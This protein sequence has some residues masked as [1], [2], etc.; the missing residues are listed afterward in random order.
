MLV[1]TGTVIHCNQCDIT[2]RAPKDL[3]AYDLAER[4]RARITDFCACPQGHWDTHWVYRQDFGAPIPIVQRIETYTKSLTVWLLPV[5]PLQDPL[6]EYRALWRTR[7]VDYLKHRAFKLATFFEVGD[8]RGYAEQKAA[9][10]GKH[11]P[12]NFAVFIT[13]ASK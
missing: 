7:P 8:A 11:A 4:E 9:M 3:N 5:E 2:F 6:P 10:Y 13:S 1:R 12:H